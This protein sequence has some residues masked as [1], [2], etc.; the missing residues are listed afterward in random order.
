MQIFPNEYFSAASSHIFFTQFL[1]SLPEGCLSSP[2]FQDDQHLAVH[3]AE[4]G[5][6]AGL[7]AGSLWH[8][9]REQLRRRRE[10]KK[11]GGSGAPKR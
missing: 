1:Y 5:M 11:A 2:I 9:M 3:E 8:T 10:S 7:W 6:C 4:E